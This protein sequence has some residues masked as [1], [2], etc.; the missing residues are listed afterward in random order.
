MTGKFNLLLLVFYM[1]MFSE[2]KG[3]LSSDEQY[4]FARVIF[5]TK[6]DF[7]P[8]KIVAAEKTLK[9]QKSFVR[10]DRSLLKNRR[11]LRVCQ[12]TDFFQLSCKVHQISGRSSA[13]PLSFALI[14]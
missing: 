12:S 8:A 11:N 6:R 13:H 14:Y 2:K 7:E 1:L 5:A 4:L 3:K 9:V 10:S